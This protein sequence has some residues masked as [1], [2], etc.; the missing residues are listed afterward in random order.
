MANVK[1]DLTIENG[2]Y[3]IIVDTS[4]EGVDVKSKGVYSGK[5]LEVALARITR[6]DGRNQMAAKKCADE[7]AMRPDRIYVLGESASTTAKME[8]A[9]AEARQDER[10][11][12]IARRDELMRE[13]NMSFEDATNAALMGE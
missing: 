3:T 1:Y 5:S 9:K 10:A 4:V 7:V 11:R 6:I 2:V 13:K 8:A 12:I